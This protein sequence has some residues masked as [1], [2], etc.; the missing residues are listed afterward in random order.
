[1]YFKNFDETIAITN[2]SIEL[3]IGVQRIKPQLLT[4][5]CLTECDSR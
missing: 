2:V 3:N 1:M 4:G 5:S